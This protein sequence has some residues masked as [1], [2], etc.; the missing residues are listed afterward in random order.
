MVVMTLSKSSVAF[1]ALF[2]HVKI[3]SGA[4]LVLPMGVAPEAV[5]EN[6]F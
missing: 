4:W 5:F 3:S 2:I 6:V 1:F